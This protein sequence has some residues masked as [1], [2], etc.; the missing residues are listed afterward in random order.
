MIPKYGIFLKFFSW[1][2][3]LKFINMINANIQEMNEPDA[4]FTENMF[5]L[6][7]F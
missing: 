7:K 6:S 4:K 2:Q 1:L 3:I 5:C